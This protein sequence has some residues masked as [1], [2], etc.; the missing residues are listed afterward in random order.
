MI[1]LANE[2]IPLD[3][4]E[5]IRNYNHTVISIKE[6]TLGISDITVLNL[7]K[8]NNAIILT[9]DKDYGEIIFRERYE[10]PPPI[11][12]YRFKGYDSFFAGKTLINLLKNA[13][14]NLNNC[15]TVIEE[16][17]IRQRKFFSLKP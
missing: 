4:I 16:E 11:I 17:T 14:I 6:Q 8:T 12:F 9:F 3:S 10:N 15:F 5:L 2:N 1:F 7:A 13:A